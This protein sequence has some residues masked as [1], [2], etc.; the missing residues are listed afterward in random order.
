MLLNIGYWNKMKTLKY[1]RVDKSEDW[2][3]LKNVNGNK[4]VQR[5]ASP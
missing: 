5:Y 1:V 3:D 2:F 4:E